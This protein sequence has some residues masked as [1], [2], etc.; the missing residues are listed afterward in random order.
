MIWE[1]KL[2][3]WGERMNAREQAKA[4][5][6]AQSTGQVDVRIHTNVLYVETNKEI[7]YDIVSL[8]FSKLRRYDGKY[9]VMIEESDSHANTVEVTV[10]TNKIGDIINNSHPFEHMDK[11]AEIIEWNEY[12]SKPANLKSFFSFVKKF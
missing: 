8:Y 4:I 1:W 7:T 6:L 2:N 3:K 5:L 9:W 11:I 10:E 12:I